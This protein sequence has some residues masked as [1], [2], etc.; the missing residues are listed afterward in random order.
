MDALLVKKNVFKANVASAEK[1]IEKTVGDVGAITD[2]EYD[3]H[4]EDL[5]KTQERLTVLL[6]KS[7]DSEIRKMFEVK[8]QVIAAML[9]KLQLL[10]FG[11]NLQEWLLFKDLFQAG[12]YNNKNWIGAQKN[13]IS[14]ANY[15]DAWTRL[16]ARYENKCE[17]VDT[18]KNSF[19]SLWCS[20]NLL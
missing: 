2:K 5:D 3:T 20:R 9:P 6:V 15:S 7:A 17:L 4:E 8:W 16:N 18:L 11:R 1:A 13:Y 12:V 19:C 14:S 10:P